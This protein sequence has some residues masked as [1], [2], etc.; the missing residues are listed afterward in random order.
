LFLIP[1]PLGLKQ[2]HIY[3]SRLVLPCLQYIDDRWI[4]EW[5]GKAG[6]NLDDS[7]CVRQENALK[8]LYVVCEILTRLG[9][10]INIDKSKFVP[11]AVIRFLG[12]LVDSDRMSFL[13]PE[14]KIER[15]LVL[16][17]EILRKQEVDLNTLQ[18]FAGRCI[19]FLLAIPSAKF[20]T[21]EVNKAISMAGKNSGHVTISQGL[22]DEISHW[23]FLQCRKGC[24]PWRGEKHLQVSMATD[25]SGYKLGALDYSQDNP[26][27]FSDLKETQA[28]I[29]GLKAVSDVVRDHRVDAYVDNLTCV[30][31]WE[32]RKF[33]YLALNELMKDLC[34]FTVEFNVDL[35]LSYFPSENSADS[36]SRTLSA[37]DCMLNRNKFLLIE[38]KFGPHQFDLMSLDSNVMQ[39]KDGLPLCHY[40]PF[41]TPGSAGVNVFSQTLCPSDN[42]Y[43]FPPFALILLVLSYLRS[44]KVK[45]CTMVVP[46]DDVKP[47]WWP[48]LYNSLVDHIIIGKKGE[49]NV[50]LLPSKK[51]FVCNKVGLR[52]DLWAA[53]LSF[54]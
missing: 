19:S 17:D 46:C 12:M 3:I 36:L 4:G 22:R 6:D 25:S 31:A 7:Q 40:T 42:L 33:K 37:Q 14:D 24:F 52:C 49:L 15:F 26:T 20:Y 38:K 41:P 5:L 10:F 1:F 8:S 51:G 29:N 45:F 47:V 13:V 21:K 44:Q 28:L 9:Y 27:K 30:Q 34:N 16:K 48:V 18:K 53:R 32:K 50:L 23:T 43:V 39:D 54:D 35:R 2:V 11:S